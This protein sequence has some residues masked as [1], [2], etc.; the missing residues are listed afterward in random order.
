MGRQALCF[1]N[2]VI[3]AAQLWKVLGVLPPFLVRIR[4][5]H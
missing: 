5:G 3:H 4:E 2:V 1:V